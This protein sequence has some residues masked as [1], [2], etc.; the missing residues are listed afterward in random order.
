MAVETKVLYLDPRTELLLLV[1]A[2]IVAFTY[3]ARWIEFAVIG[4]L[5]LLLFCCGCQRLAVQWILFFGGLIAV[6]YYVLPILPQMLVIMFS[7]L[8][9]YIRKLFPCLM[10]GALILKTTP[11]RFLIIALRKWHIP[12]NMIIPLSITLRYFPAI[13]EEYHHI[14]DAMKLRKMKGLGRKLECL[15]VPLLMS[16]ASTA[17]ELSAAAITRGIENPNPKTCMVDLKFHFK[18]YLCL[19]VGGAFIAA[20]ILAH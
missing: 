1:I 14:H 8:T 2:N 19:L 5:T 10:I 17:D 6:Q 3:S 13:K 20:A 7:I 9:V 12:Q 11:V 4:V 16:A 18:D 15:I